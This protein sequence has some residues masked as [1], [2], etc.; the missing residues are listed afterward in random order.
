MI[1]VS[2]IFSFI[3]LFCNLYYISCNSM[4]NLQESYTESELKDLAGKGIF[5]SKGSDGYLL[6]KTN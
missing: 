1:N 5:G 3:I 2:L 4:K 6:I